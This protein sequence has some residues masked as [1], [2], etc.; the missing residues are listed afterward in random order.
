MTCA[1]A[2]IYCYKKNNKKKNSHLQALIACSMHKH[3]RRPGRFAMTLGRQRVDTRQM[4][5]CGERE[6][7]GT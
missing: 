1:I 6:A 4:G 5:G 2:Q 7:R 3:R